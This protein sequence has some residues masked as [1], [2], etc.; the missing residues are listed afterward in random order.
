MH[1]PRRELGQYDVEYHDVERPVERASDRLFAIVRDADNVTA[2]LQEV[3][4]QLAVFDTVVDDQDARAF[5]PFS[6]G[7]VFLR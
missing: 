7:A 5:D 3:P 1:R 2:R 6:H 4:V